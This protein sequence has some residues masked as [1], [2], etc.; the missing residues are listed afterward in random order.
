MLI[1]ILFL[2]DL[3]IVFFFKYKYI[4]ISFL[5]GKENEKKIPV[6]TKWT[7]KHLGELR[8]LWGKGHNFSFF[9]K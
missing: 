1:K 6:K 5:R 8:V 2:C 3:K 7:W 9:H 4:L